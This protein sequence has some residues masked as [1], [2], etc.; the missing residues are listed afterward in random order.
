MDVQL[1]GPDGFKLCKRIRS[2]SNFRDLPVL[3]LTGRS[4]DPD[5]IEYLHVDGTAYLT[6][7]VKREEFLSTVKELVAG[8]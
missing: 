4:T 8:S 5:F 1:P 7:P 6:K 2:N 3:F